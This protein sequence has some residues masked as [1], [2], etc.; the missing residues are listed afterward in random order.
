MY[1][2]GYSL[3]HVTSPA[4][5]LSLHENYAM[6]TRAISI[7]SSKVLIQSFERHARVTESLIGQHAVD[8]NLLQEEPNKGIKRHEVI[9]FLT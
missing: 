4:A 3:G 1:V 7:I 8:E 2:G 9:I 6:H 5:F